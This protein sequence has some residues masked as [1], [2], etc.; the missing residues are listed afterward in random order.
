MRD[1]EDTTGRE[2]LLGVEDQISHLGSVVIE[3]IDR[4][5]ESGLTTKHIEQQI[6]TVNTESIQNQY[7]KQLPLMKV[8]WSGILDLKKSSEEAQGP[9]DF[10]GR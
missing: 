2:L 4:Y 9:C 5:L 6:E 3:H 1:F 10:P 7:I 8:I